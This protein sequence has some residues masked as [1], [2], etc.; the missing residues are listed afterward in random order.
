ML[1]FCTLIWNR[2]HRFSLCV[3]ICLV[4]GNSPN[5]DRLFYM[6]TDRTYLCSV[7]NIKYFCINIVADCCLRGVVT[8]WSCDSV[9]FG[10]QVP[11]FCRNIGIYVLNYEVLIPEKCSCNIDCHKNLKFDIIGGFIFVICVQ[12]YKGGQCILNTKLVIT[13]T[14]HCVN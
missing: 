2:N 6:Y 8:P 10:R 11:V 5:T 14:V 3:R 4:G 9:C 1:K 13:V 7:E 12:K